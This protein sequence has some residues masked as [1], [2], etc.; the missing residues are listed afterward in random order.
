MS[1]LPRT[2]PSL[3]VR[4]RDPRDERAW[5]EFVEIYEPLIYRLAR[6]RGLQDA[7]AAELVQEVFAAVSSAVERWNP[8]RRQGKFRSWLFTVARNLMIDRLRTRRRH[9]QG[10]GKTEVR[11]ALE[12]QPAPGAPEEAGL[13]EL[14]YQRQVFR[15]AVE[16]IRDEFRENTWKAF[17]LTA[18]DGQS[19]KDV[20]RRLGL[21]V[22]AVYKCR[23]RVMGRLRETVERFE[24]T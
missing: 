24:E 15:W 21:T 11:R 9:T 3:M 13:F 22:G 8:D 18:V 12:Q 7:D 5:E 17:W 14:E 2:R 6:G 16:Q 10:S 23:S 4:L 20:A 19:P 1:E